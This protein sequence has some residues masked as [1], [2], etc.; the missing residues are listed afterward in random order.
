MQSVTHPAE[1][2]AGGGQSV[3]DAKHGV[4]QKATQLGLPALR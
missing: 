3:V 1:W 2:A 4:A